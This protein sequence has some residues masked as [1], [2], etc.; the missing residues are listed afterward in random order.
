MASKL[1]VVLAVHPRFAQLIYEGSKRVELRRSFGG[2]GTRVA[3]IYETAPVSAVTG[4]FLLK[5]FRTMSPRLAWREF[6]GKLGLTQD[7]FR[8]Y[9]QGR[10]E[11]KILEIGK[12]ARLPSPLP[13]RAFTGRDSAP[14]SFCY[15]SRG[16]PKAVGSQL[17]EVGEAS[18]SWQRV[19]EI[20]RK[21]GV[22]I[23]SR[24]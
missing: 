19:L 10:D 22:A 23:P 15:V 4:F 14:Q 17:R 24:S 11:V 5:G 20:A 9:V 1:G 13:L 18:S 12:T 3:F 16:L 6:D 7:E 2:L 21:D 8:S